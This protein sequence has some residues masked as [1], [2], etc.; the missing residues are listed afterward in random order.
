MKSET[1][2]SKRTGR[3]GFT[4]VE[5]M[6]VIGILGLLVGILAVAV[7]PRM[8]RAQEQLELK[9]V[10]DLMDNIQLIA[11]DQTLI[12]RLNT[13]PLRDAQGRKFYEAAI[14]R[15]VLDV[16]V[17]NYLVAGATRH[18]PAPTTIRD[19]DSVELL[20]VNCDWTGPRGGDV[21]GM[22]ARR[23][24]NRR[25]F[26]TFNSTVWATQPYEDRVLI[27]WTDGAQAEYRQAI[28]FEDFGIDSAMWG[29]PE[30]IV[31]TTEP[32]ERTFD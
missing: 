15:Q 21:M 16:D 14:K 25:V 9:R 18:S 32:F 22:L 19:D 23:G 4:L 29:R 3:K 31:G 20:E 10:S 2:T 28:D 27:R 30:D 1:N 24:A 11:T 6:V 17:V 8:M 5:L 13:S 12:S 26:L 7:I